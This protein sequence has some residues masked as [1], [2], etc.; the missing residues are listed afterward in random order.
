MVSSES[1]IDHLAFCKSLAWQFQKEWR[2][3]F[4]GDEPKKVQFPRESLV[5]VILGY[6]FPGPHFDGLKQ[7]LIKGGYRVDILRAERFP[8]SYEF[9]SIKLDH[10][11]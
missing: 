5:T 6:R 7:V 10:I 9:G 3:V 2:L 11:G 8:N 4:P 1:P